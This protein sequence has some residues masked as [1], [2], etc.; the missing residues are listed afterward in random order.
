[1]GWTAAKDHSCGIDCKDA[2]HDFQGANRK[3]ANSSD[4]K[5][6]RGAWRKCREV[7][8]GNLERNPRAAKTKEEYSNEHER[9]YGERGKGA[10][11]GRLSRKN[12]GRLRLG[13]LRGEEKPPH[14]AREDFSFMAKEHRGKE[15]IERRSGL[16]LALHQE[17]EASVRD[18]PALNGK[19]GEDNHG[20]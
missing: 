19:K 16:P 20:S 7:G 1:M 4:P 6:K 5:K 11:H 18:D 3:G 2:A 13:K 8:D 14:A 9:K 10:L 12:V 15:G 17:R